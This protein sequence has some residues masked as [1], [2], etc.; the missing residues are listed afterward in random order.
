MF[1]F[2]LIGEIHN[3]LAPNNKGVFL[4][5]RWEY[6]S[7]DISQRADNTERDKTKISYRQNKEYLDRNEEK[8][9]GE[10]EGKA[11]TAMWVNK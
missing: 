8:R 6:D 11:C 2:L 3:G 1:T 9:E 5:E 10:R 4:P 7:P